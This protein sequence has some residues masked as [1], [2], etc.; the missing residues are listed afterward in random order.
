MVATLTFEQARR[1]V[2]DKVAE[3]RVAPRTELVNL[4]EA[5]RSE[6]FARNLK[7][8]YKAETGI[9]AEVYRSRASAGAH[10]V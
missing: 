9:D 6:Q 7:I 10:R 3:A 4:V 8:G 2:L 5:A 1:C